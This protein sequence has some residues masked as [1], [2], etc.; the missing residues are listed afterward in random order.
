MVA[1]IAHYGNCIGIPTI[2]GEVY[3]D[4][5]YDGNPL[6]NVFCLGILRHEQIARGAAKGIGNPVFYVGAE[7]GR[8]G[9]AGAAFA[10][11]ELTEESKQDRPAVQVGDPFKRKAP[12][13]SLPRTARHRR[14]RRH[15]GHG[16]G[17]PHLLDV[18]D[19]EPRRHRRR[20]RPRES[21]ASARPA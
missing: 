19:R 7:T 15:S 17:G 21:A 13:R 6:V 18:R 8:D 3:F 14:G 9:L 20:D 4:E 5:S 16:R 12:A 11:R 1:G 10:S 2:G